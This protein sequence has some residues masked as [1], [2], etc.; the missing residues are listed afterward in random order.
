MTWESA[1]DVFRFKVNISMTSETKY[2]FI[3]DIVTPRMMLS[4][5]AQ[6]YDPVGL[7]V[8]YI[9]EG[10]VLMRKSL[11]SE[12]GEVDT[13]WDRPI[14]GEICKQWDRFFSTICKGYSLLGV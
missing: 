4:Q 11:N 9:L 8:P 1:E 6:I 12:S 14:Q 2:R 3:P 5:V 10:K 13:K 7:V